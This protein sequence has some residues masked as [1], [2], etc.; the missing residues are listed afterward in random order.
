MSVAT[1][2]TTYYSKMT[3]LICDVIHIA[4]GGLPPRNTHFSEAQ[5]ATVPFNCIWLSDICIAASM[6]IP[7]KIKNSKNIT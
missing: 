4:T 7:V 6:Q 5:G 3:L 1:S 2:E